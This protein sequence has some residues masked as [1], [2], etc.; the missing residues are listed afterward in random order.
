LRPTAERVAHFAAK[1]GVSAEAILL[2]WLLRH[3]AGIQPIIGTTQVE[4]LIAASAADSIA[5]DREDWYDL[6]TAAR[7]GP[8]P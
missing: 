2:A 4:R 8:V 1:Y 7:G 5:L 6:F 3:P